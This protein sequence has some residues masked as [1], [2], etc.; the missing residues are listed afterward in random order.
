MGG[1]WQR[2]GCQCPSCTQALRPWVSGSWY[3]SAACVSYEGGRKAHYWD[4]ERMRDRW[5]FQLEV[6]R[7]SVLEA[8]R[9]CN[10]CEVR[11]RCLDDAIERGASRVVRGGVHPHELRLRIRSRN[12][13][14]PQ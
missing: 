3:E 10:G 6:V 5:G 12:A 11:W 9:V 2:T 4:P 14:D 13:P 8:I 1:N 7:A